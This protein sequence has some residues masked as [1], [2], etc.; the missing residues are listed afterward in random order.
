MVSKLFELEVPEI[1]SGQVEIKSIAREPGSR[2]KIAV[3]AT[4]EGID[5]IGSMVGQK[6]TRIWAVI[7][8]LAGEK[9]D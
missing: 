8:E 6:G 5:P 9:I 3:T 4:E 1:S 2:S 7:N